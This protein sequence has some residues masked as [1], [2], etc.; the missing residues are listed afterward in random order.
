[1]ITSLK[2]QAP[3]FWCLLIAWLVLF[4]DAKA[5]QICVPLPEK[6]LAD[7][8]LESDAVVMAREDPNRP[9][10]YAAIETLKGDP[11]STPIDAF[12]NSHSRRLLAMDSDRTMVLARNPL[13]GEWKA[14]GI[15][16]GDFELVVRRVLGFADTWRPMETDN[17]ERLAVFSKLLGHPD[18]RLHELAYLEIGRAP[19]ASISKISSVVPIETVRAILDNP[20][21]LE[22]RSL[23][24]LMLGRSNTPA[25]RARVIKTFETKQRL[26]STL[27]LAAWTTAYIETEGTAG[28]ER[29][30]QSYLAHKGR[31][32]DELEQIIQA[33]SVH[34]AADNDKRDQIVSA[35][36]SLLEAHP[37]MASY[38][39][40]DLIAWGRW[41]FANQLGKI[42]KAMR[43]NDPLGAYSIDRYLGVARSRQETSSNNE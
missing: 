19:Y 37:K 32:R 30:K 7:R 18:S 38:V 10:H 4:T 14:L 25:D 41:D 40:Q 29:I 43:R 27:N 39:V 20:R 8:L 5:C 23:A 24:I 1:M 6:T 2:R 15:A 22:W 21:Y 34:G 3:I 36:R 42:R 28:L 13:E 35:Y 31:S 16:D 26:G 12:L 9:F 17:K 11:G 33:L